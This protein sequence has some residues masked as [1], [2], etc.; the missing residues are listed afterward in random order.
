MA[1]YRPAGRVTRG[2]FPELARPISREEYGRA[3]AL[4]GE[5]GLRLDG[6]NSAQ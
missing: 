2:E 4:A 1:K 6:T 3:L 5:L